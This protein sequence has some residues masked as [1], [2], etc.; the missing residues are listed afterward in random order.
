MQEILVLVHTVHP[1]ID[2]FHK[3]CA[4]RI[5]DTRVLHILDE[6]LLEEVR[7]GGDSVQPAVDRL[8]GHVC[9]AE[10][11]GACGVL[12]TCST[13]SPW[14]DAVRPEVGIPVIKID[15]EMVLRAVEAGRR[16]GVV[17]TNPTTLKP[18]RD[19]IDAEAKRAG[20]AV[21]IR[22]VLVEGAMP[23]L[24]AG[25]GQGHD[26]LV[27][28]AL[29]GLSLQVE[30]IVLAQASTARVLDGAQPGEYPVPVLSSPELALDQVEREIFRG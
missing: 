26:R 6:P 13:V 28:A 16:I 5:P 17:A 3:A 15:E 4:E 8:L 24:L 29:A 14:I 10:R 30:V 25:D 23:A 2:I 7:Q 11:V 21:D 12:V 9:Q 18:T 19:L 27:R 1:L 22:A 20:K